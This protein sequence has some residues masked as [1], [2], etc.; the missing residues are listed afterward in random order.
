MLEAASS[1]LQAVA[2]LAAAQVEDLAVRADGRRGENEVDLPA[3]VLDVLHDVAVGLHVE[4]VEEAAPP[5]WGQ[6]GLEIRDR[7]ET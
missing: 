6:M 3:G 4:G 7:T 5:L 2:A 1:E